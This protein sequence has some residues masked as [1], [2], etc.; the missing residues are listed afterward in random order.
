[1]RSG[2]VTCPVAIRLLLQIVLFASVRPVISH[3]DSEEWNGTTLKPMP[4][5]VRRRA[6]AARACAVMSIEIDVTEHRFELL[7]FYP[8]AAVPTGS[9]ARGF[10]AC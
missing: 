3:S 6:C 10:G 1:M 4:P 2:R 5:R 9:S 7:L 8:L